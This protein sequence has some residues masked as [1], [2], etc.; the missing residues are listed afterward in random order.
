MVQEIDKEADLFL[1]SLK[2][3]YIEIR[4]EASQSSGG[5]VTMSRSK[6]LW[7]ETFERKEEEAEPQ[8][9]NERNLNKRLRDMEVTCEKVVGKKTSLD[10]HV[11]IISLGRKT[12]GITEENK[13]MTIL[14]HSK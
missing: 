13:E 14:A 12:P 4:S 6:E 3:P 10:Q 11:R 7:E 8:I 1:D 9:K 2:Q 5:S